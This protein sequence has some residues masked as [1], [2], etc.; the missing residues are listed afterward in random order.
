MIRG[1]FFDF[2]NTIVDEKP[3]ISGAQMGVVRYVKDKLNLRE[4]DEEL[5]AK[6]RNTPQLPAGHPL[7]LQPKDREYHVRRIWMTEFAK[8]CGMKEN[9]RLGDELMVAY[10][11]GAKHSDCLIKNAGEILRK[12]SKNYCLCII[13]NGYAGFIYATLDFHNL[14]RYFKKIIISQEVNLEKPA[15][16]MFYLALDSCGIEPG[17]AMMVG[18][19]YEADV[20]GAKA[21]GM[22][23]CWV[24]PDCKEPPGADY[25]F[26]IKD[27]SELP[28]ILALKSAD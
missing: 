24:N 3:F 15:P 11:N 22:K 26:M 10:D 27:I 28:G 23:A 9:G 13:S 16:E 4:T 8:S 7:R 2:G 21:V 20:K 18:D 17:E 1:V 25:D 14:R 5:Y 12:L 6:L 19:S